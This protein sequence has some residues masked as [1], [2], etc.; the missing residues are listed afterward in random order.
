MPTPKLDTTA[1]E[2]NRAAIADPNRIPIT[3]ET[4]FM[5][6]VDNIIN[7]TLRKPLAHALRGLS[8]SDVIQQ[9]VN[10]LIKLVPRISEPPMTEPEVASLE[11]QD[12]LKIGMAVMGF[13]ADKEK[14]SLIESM[15]S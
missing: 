11:A 12:I 4:G 15:T 13:F 14:K 7:V 10:A 3:L 9:D 6:G 5:R 2:L 1:A 8:I